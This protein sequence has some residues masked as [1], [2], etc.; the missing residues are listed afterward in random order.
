MGREGAGGGGGGGGGIHQ[1]LCSR[2]GQLSPGARRH[3]LIKEGIPG[4]A[5]C[6]EDHGG[7]LW[8]CQQ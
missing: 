1:P 8:C 2:R 6:A 7:A 4:S 5:G 3:P